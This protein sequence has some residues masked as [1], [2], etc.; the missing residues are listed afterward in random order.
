MRNGQ[1]KKAG[2]W[3]DISARTMLDNLPLVLSRLQRD[4]AAVAT[5][6]AWDNVGQLLA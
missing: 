2:N 1:W 5:I 6:G 3:P 4:P